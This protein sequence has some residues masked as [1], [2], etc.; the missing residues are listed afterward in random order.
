[1]AKAENGK[2]TTTPYLNSEHQ[3]F[4]TSVTSQTDQL[5]LSDSINQ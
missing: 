2:A 5:F 3:D 1:M 4:K